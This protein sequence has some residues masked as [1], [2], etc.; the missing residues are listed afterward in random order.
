VECDIFSPCARGGVVNDETIEQLHC[1]AIVGSANNQ[2]QEARH[3]DYLH[4]KGILYAPD[5]LVNAGGLIQVADEVEGY[6]EKR[7]LAKT[8]AIYD[9]LLT[10]YERSQEENIPTCRAADQLVMER[11]EKVADLRRILLGFHLSGKGR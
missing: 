4:E 10:I 9:M 7:V 2:L 11:I 3:G 6:E 8:K 5:Y 1:R